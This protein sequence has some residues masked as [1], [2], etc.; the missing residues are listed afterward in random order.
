MDV[1]IIRM[2]LIEKGIHQRLSAS[3]KA[4]R[5]FVYDRA[6]SMNERQ[7]TQRV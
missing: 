7:K 2:S 6:A 1:K 5:L 4:K 3:A